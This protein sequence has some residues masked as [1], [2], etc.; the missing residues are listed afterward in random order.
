MGPPNPSRET[1]F[2]GANEN[3]EKFIFPNQL[4][5]TSKI[6]NLARLWGPYIPADTY[7]HSSTYTYRCSYTHIYMHIIQQQ[8]TVHECTCPQI[9]IYLYLV[10]K[11]IQT[12]VLSWP[13][14]IYVLTTDTADH[15]QVWQPYVVDPYYSAI[16][17]WWPYLLAPYINTDHQQ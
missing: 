17:K 14:H 3:S 16:S 4:L 5:T 8:W 15:E 13:V 12:A 11:P 7:K 10:Y 9:K 2:S 6:D 1:K